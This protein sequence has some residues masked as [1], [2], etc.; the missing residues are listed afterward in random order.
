M[1]YLDSFGISQV[2]FKSFATVR[3]DEARVS[4]TAFL[5]TPSGTS[6]AMLVLLTRWGLASTRLGGLSTKDSQNCAVQLIHGFVAGV[7]S[8]GAFDLEI[9]L[10]SDFRL[11]WPRP[12]AMA[13]SFKLRVSSTGSINVSTWD[14]IA[15]RDY[16]DGDDTALSCLLSKR[17][18]LLLRD[19]MS[20]H[21]TIELATILT[22]KII[23]NTKDLQSFRLQVAIQVATRVDA[24]C[25][26]SDKALDTTAWPLRFSTSLLKDNWHPRIVDKLCTQHL[27]A[28]RMASPTTLVHISVATDKVAGRGLQLQNAFFVTSTNVAF[29]AAP[30]VTYSCG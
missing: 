20:E 8:T 25:Y 21:G 1:R 5:P 12:P 28:S 4:T 30:Q 17:W 14:S 7:L 6:A 11:R 19:H 3:M 13:P 23:F 27:Q 18:M 26:A 2:L 29:E 15:G 16:E 10:V 9:Y 22:S 24:T